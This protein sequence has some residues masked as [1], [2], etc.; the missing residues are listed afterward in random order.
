[1]CA[2]IFATSPWQG[3]LLVSLTMMVPQPIKTRM[4][5]NIHPS[6]KST[7]RHLRTTVK[8]NNRNLICSRLV[9]IIVKYS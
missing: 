2:I 9:M 4:N 1:M 6:G 7:I 8:V 3:P 5:K